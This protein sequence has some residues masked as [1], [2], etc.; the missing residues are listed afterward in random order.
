MFIVN[1][2]QMLIVAISA[3]VTLNMFCLFLHLKG[4]FSWNKAHM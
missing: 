2:I 1:I 3:N 4:S